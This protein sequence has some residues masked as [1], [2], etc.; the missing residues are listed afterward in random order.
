MM[1]I[2]KILKTNRTFFIMREKYRFNFM[3]ADYGTSDS[4]NS[5]DSVK[6]SVSVDSMNSMNSIQ[7]AQSNIMA[8]ALKN[9][10]VVSMD[11]F[12]TKA[13]KI[14]SGTYWTDRDVNEFVSI[15]KVID[16]NDIDT[17]SYR[18]SIKALSKKLDKIY[19]IC[20]YEGYDHLVRDPADRKKMREL[21]SDVCQLIDTYFPLLAAL[22]VQAYPDAKL[23]ELEQQDPTYKKLI[24]ETRTKIFEI[25]F[26]HK[27][28]RAEMK[29]SD[30]T[31]KT[32]ADKTEKPDKF[33]QQMTVI[34]VVITLI[35]CS[36]IYYNASASASA[37]TS[38]TE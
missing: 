14:L 38:E 29:K 18:G 19:G 12:Q 28:R 11:K 27:L 31:D 8:A 7:S 36:V 2:L 25:L 4:T 24:V 10:G 5:T 13:T 22:L 17:A 26:L 20:A 6:S 21:L 37:S 15:V 35:I 32:H 16:L 9:K 3:D 23:E 34:V 33:Y 1:K 30:K